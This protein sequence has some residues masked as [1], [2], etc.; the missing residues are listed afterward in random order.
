MRILIVTNHFWPENFRITDLAVDMQKRGHEVSVLTG[1]PD[2]PE[3]RFYEG[4]GVF[5]RR[6]EFYRG[7]KVFRFP[8]IPRGKGRAWE[9][10]LNYFSSAFFSCMLAPFYCRDKYDVIFVFDTSPITIGLPAIILKKLKSI[11]LIFWV[12]DLWPESLSATGAVQ[13]SKV[14]GMVRQL[15]R[16]I[17]G[18]C[19]RILIS[20]RGFVQSIDE[21]G[22]YDHDLTY[23]P[24]WVE[25][26]YLI[27]K[28]EG[29]FEALPTLPALPDGFR[30]MFA[31]NIGVAQDFDTILT[32]AELLA[33]YPDIH[34]V[35]L[36]DG[37]MAEWV[38]EQIRQRNL[39]GQFHMLGRYPARTMPH[40][41]AQAD[42]LLMTLR[43][44]PIFALTVPGKLQSY[45]ACGKPI[46]AGLDG[47]GGKLVEESGAGLACP[48]ESPRKLADRVLELYR[49]PLSVRN[50]FGE[51]GIRYCKEHFDRSIL[52][53]KLE[54]IMVELVQKD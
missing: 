23:F 49:M 45:M 46:I 1:V 5:K 34:W 4:Y 11:P 50:E 36:G 17:H 51:Q 39:G 54:K 19:D 18:Q 38:K 27:D 40:F 29:T 14:L 31:G 22:G 25:P 52:F 33:S 9:L 15:V 26:E 41:F 53:N 44:E 10:A 2:Y 35:I 8:L 3:G 30:V 32:A 21:T 12:L 24:N 37:R 42:A 6:F 7:V 28:A 47:E 20:S 48:A 16:F 13:S 43:R